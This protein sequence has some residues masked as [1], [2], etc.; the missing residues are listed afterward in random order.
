MNVICVTS[1]KYITEI[2]K[3]V[4]LNIQFIS[5][6]TGINNILL[7][8][9][10]DWILIDI[11]GDLLNCVKLINEIRSTDSCFRL[12]IL[13]DN[14]VI[15]NVDIDFYFQRLEPDIV[16]GFYELPMCLHSITPL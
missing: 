8:T 5:N 7:T 16:S 12:V 2:A 11:H 13:V 1:K 14:Y 15:N 9:F 10:V 3:S 6:I 4:S